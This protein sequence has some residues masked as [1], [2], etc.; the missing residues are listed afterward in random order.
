VPAVTLA[1]AV[2]FGVS[3]LYFAIATV[4]RLLRSVRLQWQEIG[5]SSLKF[6]MQKHGTSYPCVAEALSRS[7]PLEQGGVQLREM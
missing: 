7:A 4:T 5:S 6:A 3:G 1:R 2:N